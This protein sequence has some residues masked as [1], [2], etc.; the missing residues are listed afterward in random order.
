MDAFRIALC[1]LKAHGIE[2]AEANLQGIL[3]ALDE[4]GNA[5]AQLAVLPE[6]SYPAYFLRDAEPYS[7][8]N[9]RQFAD[10]LSLLSS[11]ATRYSYWIAAGLAVPNDDG[12]LTNSAVLIDPQGRWVDSYEKCFLWH[13]DSKWFRA[14][15]RFPVWDLGFAKVGALICADGRMPEI[16]RSLALNGAEVILDL[17][18]WVSSGRDLERLSNPQAEY[19]MQVRAFEN[20]VWVA[21]AD[22]WGVEAGSIV[23]AGRSCV[24]DPEGVNVAS[25][26]SNEGGVLIHEI[27][28][29]RVRAG[30]PRRPA[31][32]RSLTTPTS[33]LPIARLLE[34]P[35]V[36]AKERGRIA[37]APS[38]GEFNAERAAGIFRD[39]R[40]QDADVVVFGGDDG[41][42][43]WQVALPPLEA[44]VRELGGAMVLGVA[45]TGCSAHQ[46]TVL[47]TSGQTVE[48]VATHGRGIQLGEAP[49]PII[50]TP[51][52]NLGLLC[53]E[54]GYL[55]EVARGLMLAGADLL[56]WPAF[57]E[58]PMTDAIARTRA[59]ENRVY[60]ASAGPGWGT[61][62]APTGAP[63]A[64][65]P[66]GSGAAMAAATNR[67][68]SRSKEMAPGTNVV[69]DRQPEAYGALV[70]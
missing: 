53:G 35:V 26:G 25:L 10:V 49:S 68:V 51:A 29:R 41:P 23:Y 8:D 40:A 45:T 58:L 38:C 66:S 63:L 32:Y 15:N 64:V 57:A 33:S 48:H 34:E 12:G 5:G 36:P 59:D 31:L 18:A 19:M 24:I 70:R 9:V 3:A 22:K 16:A 50:E 21:A 60:V 67:A 4:A 27:S 56:A 13:F 20:G 55:P 7:R 62:Y 17:T 61:I 30:V 46:S 44:L 43:G 14:G 47:I 2:D 65:S 37:V 6:C 39:L 52:G 28:P 54:E 69:L 11:Y 42:E 1:Q